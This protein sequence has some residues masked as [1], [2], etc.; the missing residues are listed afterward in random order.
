MASTFDLFKVMLV[1][2]AFFSFGITMLSHSLPA[3]SLVY[4]TGFNTAG[5]GVDL[6]TISGQVQDSL[7]QQTN[8]PVIELASLVFYSG[9]VIIDLLVNFVFAIPEMVGMLLNGI[10]LLFGIDAVIWAQV[11]LF[12][13]VIM[14][15][16]YFIGL[17]QILTNIRTGRLV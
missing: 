14:V 4:V 15:T 12:F 10:L 11:E 8:A 13:S 1:V 3:E 9:N 17:I 5:G 6:E 2:S 16:L 7:N